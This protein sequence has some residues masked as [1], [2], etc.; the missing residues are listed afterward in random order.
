MTQLVLMPAALAD[1]ER[2]RD[3][4]LTHDPDNAE[5]RFLDLTAAL[6]VLT[7]A[8]EIGRR[9]G[10]RA[11]ELVIGRGARGYVARYEY[12]ARLEAAFILRVHHQREER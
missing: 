10:Q 9:V 1:L 7:H 5:E 11:R 6:D 3:F 12:V 4:L 2:I 8:P